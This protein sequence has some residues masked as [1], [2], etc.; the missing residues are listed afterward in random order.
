MGADEPAAQPVKFDDNVAAGMRAMG[1]CEAE[2]E[3]H[4]GKHAVPETAPDFEVYADNWVSVLFFLS[5]RTQW[6]FVTDGMG[7]VKRLGLIYPAVESAMRMRGTK[8][9]KQLALLED[10]QVMEFAALQVVEERAQAHAAANG[11]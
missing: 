5:L 2:I 3:R 6:A 10:V 8:R 7:F 9:A 4:Q 1:V 11:S